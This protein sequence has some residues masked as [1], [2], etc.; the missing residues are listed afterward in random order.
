[1]N[2]GYAK[3]VDDHV[4]LRE[5]RAKAL[6]EGFAEGFAKGFAKGFVKG[7]AEGWAEGQA[8]LVLL[9]LG[10]KFGPLPKWARAR[11]K[12]A[13][14]AQLE[15]WAIGVLTAETLAEVVGKR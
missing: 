5:I 1:M 3:Y 11:V 9:L 12:E 10:A 8:K 4:Y 2:R 7:F 15:A 14:A 13:A 6:A